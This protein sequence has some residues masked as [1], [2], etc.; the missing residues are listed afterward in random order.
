M[1]AIPTVVLQRHCLGVQASRL[2]SCQVQKATFSRR[3]V[4]RPPE[5]PWRLLPAPDM[6]EGCSITLEP[7]LIGRSAKETNRLDRQHQIL[8]QTT[9][10]LLYPPCL[11][12]S[13]FRHI[14]D[15]AAGTAVWARHIL[16]GGGG[17]ATNQTVQLNPGCVVDFSDVSNEQIPKPTPQGIG[18]VFLYDVLNPFPQER[19]G[20][21]DLIHQ[22]LL[23]AAIGQGRWPQVLKNLRDGLGQL[24]SRTPLPTSAL[25]CGSSTSAGRFPVLARDQSG[26]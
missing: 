23:V 16:S 17:D 25:I 3:T 24:R 5:L 22:R 7:Y 10:G 6:A 18:E 26:P 13:S 15:C 11:D 21:Y 20:N 12:L 14:L 8:L 1:A 4:L 2:D 9:G 19:L